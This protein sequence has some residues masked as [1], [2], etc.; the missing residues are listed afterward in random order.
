MGVHNL[1][2]RKRKKELIRSI[3]AMEVSLKNIQTCLQI[4]N[5][6]DTKDSRLKYIANELN[7]I[8]SEYSSRMKSFRDEIDRINDLIEKESIE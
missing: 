5:R 2:T 3:K 7:Y 6:P 8:R 1:A 4:L